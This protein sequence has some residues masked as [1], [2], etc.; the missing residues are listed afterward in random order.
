MDA[1]LRGK[2]AELAKEIAISISTQQ[3]LGDVMRLMTKSVIECMLD[4][5]MDAH[6]GQERGQVLAKAAIPNAAM[7]NA[8]AD[9][10]DETEAVRG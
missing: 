9:R 1:I 6:L 3:E 10:G 8:V 5:E 2:A 7:Q 4:A